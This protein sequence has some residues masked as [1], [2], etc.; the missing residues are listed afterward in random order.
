[1]YTN[2]HLHF[3]DMFFFTYIHTTKIK[4]Q[5]LNK[6]YIKQFKNYKINPPKNL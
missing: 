1:M 4:I 5:Q 3:Y 6:N 2:T